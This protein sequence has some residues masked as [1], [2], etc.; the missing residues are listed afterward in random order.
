MNGK[1]LQWCKHHYHGYEQMRNVLVRKRNSE[2][3]VIHVY[4]PLT[5]KSG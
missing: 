5:I 2:A 4:V 1:Q 3:W